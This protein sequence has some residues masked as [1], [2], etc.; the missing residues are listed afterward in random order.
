MIRPIT[1]FTRKALIPKNTGGR[2]SAV[3]R[4]CVISASMKAFDCCC[5][6]S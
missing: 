2:I 5:V 4:S 6:R 1:M 3:E